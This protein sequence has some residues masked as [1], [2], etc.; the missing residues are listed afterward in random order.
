MFFIIVLIVMGYLSFLVIQ[1]FIAAIL[2]GIVLAYLLH[3]VFKRLNKR[4]R[5]ENLTAFVMSLAIIVIIALPAVF[6]IKETSQEAR[7]FFIT[8]KQS[9]ASDRFLNIDCP[10]ENATFCR[11]TAGI[12]EFIGEEDVKNYI[13]QGITKA[14]DFVLSQAS[15]WVFSLPRIF[16]LI[17]VTFFVC[18]YGTV[19]GESWVK[20]FKGLLPIKKKYQKEIFKKLDTI[21]H[22]VIFGSLLIAAIQ[23]LLGGLGFYLTGVHSPVLWG[24]VMSVFALVPFLGT[25]VVWLPITLLMILEGI[26]ESNNLVLIMGVCLF[27]YCAL[28][29]STIDNILK[30]RL[31]GKKAEVHP[32]TVLVGVLGGISLLGFIGFI[33]G[34]LILSVFIA[35]LEVY[36]KEKEAFLK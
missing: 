25:A 27:L 14:S 10:D 36:Q 7:F 12:R 32:I 29:V 18:F 30:P 1:P 19:E 3:P 11:M 35:F 21:T 16:L 28:I 34:P 23:G 33:I 17:F 9:I 20:K 26:V 31:I 4:F 2:S 5:N 8:A 15:I 24:M 22:A 6:M 13:Y